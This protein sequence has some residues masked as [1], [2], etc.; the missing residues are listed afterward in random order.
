[1]HKVEGYSAQELV[2]M[3]KSHGFS[4]V[5]V[6][7]FGLPVPDSFYSTL[8]RRLTRFVVHRLEDRIPYPL[9]LMAIYEKQ[10]NT[11]KTIKPTN[12]NSVKCHDKD[13]SAEE[14]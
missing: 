14:H 8:P 1:V 5:S 11:T 6:R 3:G 2:S 4:R 10:I 12:R 9:R 7:A 13:S